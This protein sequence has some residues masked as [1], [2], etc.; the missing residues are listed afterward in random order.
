MT[1]VPVEPVY[2]TVAAHSGD[3]PLTMYSAL[4]KSRWSVSMADRA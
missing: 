1:G 3:V 2:W 4:L